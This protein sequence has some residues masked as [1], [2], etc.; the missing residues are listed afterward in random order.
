MSDDK[1]MLALLKRLET[2]SPTSPIGT[3]QI[4]EYGGETFTKPTPKSVHDGTGLWIEPRWFPSEPSRVGFTGAVSNYRGY[5]QA[6]C[7]IHRG[8][9]AAYYAG[10]LASQVAAHFPKALKLT[11]D[12]VTVKVSGDTGAGSALEADGELRI[13][14]I[15]RYQALA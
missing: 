15:I 8:K 5:L 14:V 7:C 10:I 12:D 1:I 2:F 6:S 4:A 13:P 9:W 3:V 11:E